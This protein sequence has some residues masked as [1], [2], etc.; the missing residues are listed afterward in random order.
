MTT[1]VSPSRLAASLLFW[2]LAFLKSCRNPQSSDYQRNSPGEPLPLKLRCVWPTDKLLTTD[3][4]KI[5]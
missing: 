3:E 2:F 1:D 4:G 5:F